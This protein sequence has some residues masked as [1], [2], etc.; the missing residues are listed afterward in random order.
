MTGCWCGRIRPVGDGRVGGEHPWRRGLSWWRAG[1]AAAL[2]L[3]FRPLVQVSGGGASSDWSRALAAAVVGQG[4]GW[5]CPFFFFVRRRVCP[6]LGVSLAV[7]HKQ[8][9]LPA[10]SYL[11]PLA[12]AAAG[13]GAPTRRWASAALCCAGGCPLSAGDWW[14]VQRLVAADARLQWLCR[15]LCYRA[16]CR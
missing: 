10:A 12:G 6:F 3:S 15:W 8:Q 11:A 4:R 1:A 9:Q 2:L 16:V 13:E 14:R 7:G 5:G